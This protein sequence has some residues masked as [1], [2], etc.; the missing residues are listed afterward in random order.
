MSGII[1]PES[2]VV[3]L[4]PRTRPS[5]QTFPVWADVEGFPVARQKSLERF[6][7]WAV[8][9]ATGP[10][11]VSL[12][13]KAVSSSDRSDGLGI[14]WDR[15]AG[16]LSAPFSA[17]TRQWPY[18]LAWCRAATAMRHASLESAERALEQIDL[19]GCGGQCCRDH[20]LRWMTRA[21]VKRTN[22]PLEVWE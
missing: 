13:R 15:S 1:R 9:A 6:P 10:Q 16:T 3:D 11:A 2:A 22:P 7:S 21:E 14:V 4:S 8:L 17:S 5:A 18:T 20:E 12:A 19:G